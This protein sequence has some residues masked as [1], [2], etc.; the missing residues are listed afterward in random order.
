M[1][2]RYI[3]FVPAK[4]GQ[5][6][7]KASPF[8]KSEVKTTTKAPEK[9]VVAKKTTPRTVSKVAPKTE[10]EKVKAAKIR[11]TSRDTFESRKVSAVKKTIEKDTGKTVEKRADKVTHGAKMEIPKNP[12]IAN[13][14]VSKRPLSKNVYKKEVKA[15][16]EEP[17]GPV[18]I[19]EKPEKG[20][21]V[22]LVVTIILT[23]VLG[24]TAGTVAFLLL[25]K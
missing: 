11:A 19:I 2:K 14:K 18:T 4:R 1:N 25:P 3:D 12:F 15:P 10:I 16:K 23:I 21:H 6:D 8:S 9:K 22:G 17:K 7:L 13:P 24:A 5:V 20:A